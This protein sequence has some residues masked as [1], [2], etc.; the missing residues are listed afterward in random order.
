MKHAKRF[1]ALLACLLAVVLM[2]TACSGK[3]KDV[4]AYLQD[5]TVAQQL[6]EQLSAMESSDYSVDVTAE[7]NTLIYTFAFGKQIDLSDET[8]N[9]TVVSALESGMEQQS[10]VFEG[11]VDELQNEVQDAGVKVRIV[12]NNAD[13]TEI[14]SCEFE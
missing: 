5:D 4:E 1:T 10:S 6:D 2:C 12:Y 3:P 7:G 14:Y 9:S 11:I 13:G 8:V